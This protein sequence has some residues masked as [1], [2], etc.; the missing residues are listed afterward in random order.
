MKSRK[1]Q[2]IG[3]VASK[4]RSNLEKKPCVRSRG[5]IFSL[6]IIKLGQNVCL[7]KISEGFE[8]GSCQVKN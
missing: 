5:Y 6:T 8:N 3:H 7:N 1:R 4:T 2:K